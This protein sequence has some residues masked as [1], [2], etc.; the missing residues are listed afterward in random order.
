MVWFTDAELEAVRGFQVLTLEPV[1]S[2]V[3]RIRGVKP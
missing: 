2:N 1:A 3:V